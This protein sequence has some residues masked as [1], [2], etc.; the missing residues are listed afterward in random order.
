MN[1]TDRPL[2]K[3]QERENERAEAIAYL[4]KI[5]KP[6]DTVYSVL[7]HVSKSGMSRIVSLRIVRKGEIQWIT[8]YAA[9]AMGHK[10]ADSGGRTGIKIGGCGMDMGFALV[11]ELGRTL[12]PKGFRLRKGQRGRNGDTSG[13]DDD[14]GYALRQSW[15]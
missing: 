3:K 12:W 13:F 14:G 2:T 4:H 1:A 5:L 7:R 9:R 11:Y 15:L 10:I 8:G 6:G